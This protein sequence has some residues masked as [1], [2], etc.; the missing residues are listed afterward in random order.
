MLVQQQSI[1][2]ARGQD[3]YAQPLFPHRLHRACSIRSAKVCAIGG[4]PGAPQ[5]GRWGAAAPRRERSIVGAS[6]SGRFRLQSGAGL[7]QVPKAMS[8][9]CLRDS[10]DAGRQGWS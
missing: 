9:K 5:S 7:R 2:H 1:A 3:A 6:M 4:F 8:A 10:M